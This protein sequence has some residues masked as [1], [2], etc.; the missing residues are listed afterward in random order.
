MD[1]WE[2]TSYSTMQMGNI[3]I[4]NDVAEGTEQCLMWIVW[5]SIHHPKRARNTLEMNSVPILNSHPAYW[6]GNPIVVIIGPLLVRVTQN[7][8]GWW[9]CSRKGHFY[10]QYTL[11]GPGALQSSD[12]ATRLHLRSLCSGPCPHPYLQGLLFPG[13]AAPRSPFFSFTPVP[14]V[15]LL[16]F[17]SS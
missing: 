10:G 14:L 11:M 8:G 4:G 17:L 5:I 15:P 1:D 6:G 9:G 7:P 2:D 16:S 3:V 13:G 12:S